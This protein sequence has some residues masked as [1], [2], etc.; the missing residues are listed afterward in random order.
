MKITSLDPRISALELPEENSAIEMSNA[1]GWHTYEV[2]HQKKTGTQHVHVGIVHAPNAEMA[3]IFA[4]E[5]FARRGP[6]TS[7]WVVKTA[8]MTA[9]S[10]EDADIFETTPEKLYREASFY[11]LRDKIEKYK[12]DTHEQS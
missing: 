12:L 5:S 11:K 10:P 7:L 6:T 8:D 1:E 2:F 4:K 3:M 9:T